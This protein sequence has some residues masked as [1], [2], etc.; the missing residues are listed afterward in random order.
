[1]LRLTLSYVQDDGLGPQC[2]V[3]ISRFIKTQCELRGENTKPMLTLGRLRDRLGEV[4][5]CEHTLVDRRLLLDYPK[6][7]S[8]NNERP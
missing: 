7:Y 3:G 4:L 6:W 8:G 5:R 2:R 1:M